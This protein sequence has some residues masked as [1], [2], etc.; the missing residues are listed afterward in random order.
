MY[1]QD[2][3][4]SQ[5][6]QVQLKIS[7]TTITNILIKNTSLTAT[8]RACYELKQYT[9]IVTIS[10]ATVIFLTLQ[11]SKEVGGSWGLLK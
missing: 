4:A 7:A 5:L 10:A 8:Y 2:E 1:I 11:S 6:S 3:L 9:K